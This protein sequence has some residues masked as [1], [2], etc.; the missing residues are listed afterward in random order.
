MGKKIKFRFFHKNAKMNVPNVASGVCDVATGVCDVAD[1]G[2]DV[3]T[4]EVAAVH[5]EI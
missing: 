4:A 3:A 1:V 2:C 5:L